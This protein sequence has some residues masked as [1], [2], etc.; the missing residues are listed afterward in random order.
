MQ[1]VS[2]TTA[3][4]N[5]RAVLYRSN[6]S[7]NAWQAL[8]EFRRQDGDTTLVAVSANSIQYTTQIYDPLFLATSPIDAGPG[9]GLKTVYQPYYQLNI[10]GCV[11]QYTICN[12]RFES[13]CTP[14]SGIID[15]LNNFDLTNNQDPLGLND[16]QRATAFRIATMLQNTNTY[17]NVYAT[18]DEALK[19]SAKAL[20]QLSLPLPYDQWILEVRGWFEI[21]LAKMQAYAVDYAAN[22]YQGDFGSIKIP[23]GIHAQFQSI[24]T[25]QCATQKIRSTNDIQNLSLTGIIIVAVAGGILWIIGLAFHPAIIPLWRKRVRKHFIPWTRNMK[26]ERDYKADSKYHLYFMAVEDRNNPYEYDLTHEQCPTLLGNPD[27]PDPGERAPLNISGRVNDGAI[28]Y[29]HTHQRPLTAPA[30]LASGQTNV[31]G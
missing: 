1:C 23:Q 28:V 27:L 14:V 7:A 26:H 30:P 15:L 31:S 10:V 8:P 22:T 20:N 19:A 9:S 29:H 3:N 24:F 11:D 6:G 13:R 4:L 2:K 17:S 18:G 25:E 12:P 21:G 16:H 5:P